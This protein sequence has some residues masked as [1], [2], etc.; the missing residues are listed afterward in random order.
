MKYGKSTDLTLNGV[1]RT[2]SEWCRTCGLS[3]GTYASRLRRG[4][5]P[6]EA[7]AQPRNATW[8]QSTVMLAFNGITKSREEWCAHYE[9]PVSTFKSRCQRG[10][11]P[12]EALT[13]PRITA[14]GRI[15]SRGTASGRE[16]GDT[17]G[18]LACIVVNPSWAKQDIAAGGDEIGAAIGTSRQAV[19]QFTTRALRR[20][21]V[22]LVTQVLA[23]AM[24]NDCEDY[25]SDLVA[26]A[27]TSRL[28]R[29]L[30]LGDLAVDDLKRAHARFYGRKVAA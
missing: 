30:V 26:Y 9:I 6:G 7:L 15:T 11:D 17:C 14:P 20:A 25:V 10:I 23:A 21:Q 2:Q 8:T 27:I 18:N 1:T 19:E 28:G 16:P 24:P 4:L 12:F 29:E 3:W 5:E 13:A 22:S